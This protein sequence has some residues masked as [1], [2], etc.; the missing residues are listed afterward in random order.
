MIG[1]E[2][3]DALQDLLR[4]VADKQGVV[5]HARNLYA[6]LRPTEFTRRKSRWF[7]DAGSRFPATDMPQD[8]FDDVRSKLVS[9]RGSDGE[10]C[11]AVEDIGRL[12]QAWIAYQVRRAAL[13]VRS[14]ERVPKAFY[15]LLLGGKPDLST[16][17]GLLGFLHE[18]MYVPMVVGDYRK[19]V[20][21][22]KAILAAFENGE[23]SF[24]KDA[25]IWRDQRDLILRESAFCLYRMCDQGEHGYVKRMRELL[26]D[27]PNRPLLVDGVLTHEHFAE[28]DA[29]IAER[30][31]VYWMANRDK[32]FDWAPDVQFVRLASIALSIGHQLDDKPSFLAGRSVEHTIDRACDAMVKHGREFEADLCRTAITY[33]HALEGDLDRVADDLVGYYDRAR[34]R[35]INSG[36]FEAILTLLDAQASFRVSRGKKGRA[37]WEAGRKVHQIA[38]VLKKTPGLR[39]RKDFVRLIAD[40]RRASLTAYGSDAHMKA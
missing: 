13:R 27:E 10:A 19:S 4:R 38:D 15:A 30:Q 33:G 1:E 23:G 16:L 26:N 40:V 37:L 8:A 20:I 32:A 9:A 5:V 36:Y 28:F 17:E 34:K 39:L 11:L 21:A 12:D 31:A 3:I 14:S 2:S 29:D 7:P 35:E 22:M 6:P 24:S 18:K 25:A